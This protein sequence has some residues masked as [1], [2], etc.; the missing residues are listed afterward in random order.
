MGK[1]N[2]FQKGLKRFLYHILGTSRDESDN[3]HYIDAYVHW[4]NNGK[5]HSVIARYPK[6]RYLRHC[7]IE[8]YNHLVKN[9]KL[10]DALVVSQ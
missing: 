5:Y 4:Y 1:L 8:W 2:D 10:E 7:D 6:E 9:L 3:N